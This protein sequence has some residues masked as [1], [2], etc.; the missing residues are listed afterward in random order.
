MIET[1]L[2]TDRLR[3]T[4]WEPEHL[5][6]VILLH[7]DPDVSRYL[8]VSG[9]PEDRQQAE[10]R[11]VAW[12]KDFAAQHMGKLRVSLKRDGQFLGRAGFG[13]EPN[14]EPELGYAFLR[15][16]WGNGYA[17][18]AARGLRDWIFSK[19]D[20]AYFIGFADTRNA[21]SLRILQAIGMT[22]THIAEELNGLTCQFHILR[23]ADW[24]G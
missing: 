24:H 17:I 6:E 9:E 21:A 5:D 13:I 11:L 1:V 3:L 12:A 10:A 7:S 4:N 22:K 18:E 20:H 2:E 14:G 8:S 19:T 15:R 23:K 16:H